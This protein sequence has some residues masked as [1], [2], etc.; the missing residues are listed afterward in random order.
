MQRKPPSFVP[1]C[2]IPSTASEAWRR[3]FNVTLNI[4]S[5]SSYN[6][7]GWNQEQKEIKPPR[8]D[9]NFPSLPSYN[10]RFAGMPSDWNNA[11]QERSFIDTVKAAAIPAFQGWTSIII[12]RLLETRQLPW[13]SNQENC[14]PAAGV[15]RINWFSSWGCTLTWG[16]HQAVGQISIVPKRIGPGL[17]RLLLLLS[18]KFRMYLT[19]LNTSQFYSF[20]SDGGH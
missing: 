18:P 12:W 13:D 5:L 10:E 1:S 11:R 4:I 17:K 14:I 20:Y 7:N 16:P 2:C 6:Y 3:H 15:I 8:R 9:E 19:S